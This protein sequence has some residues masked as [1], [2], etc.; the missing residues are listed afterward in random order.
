MCKETL[1]QSLPLV[2]GRTHYLG[3]R[4]QPLRLVKTFL[5]STLLRL[6][7]FR[8][9]IRKQ[10]SMFEQNKTNQETISAAE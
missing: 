1:P 3:H 9:N 7:V 8:Q 10:P 6:S 2:E 5:L 4:G